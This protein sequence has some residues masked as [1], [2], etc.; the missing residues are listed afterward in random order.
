MLQA[1]AP[2]VHELTLRVTDGWEPLAGATLEGLLRACSGMHALHIH[3][4]GGYAPHRPPREVI[5]A[6]PGHY[7]CTSHLTAQAAHALW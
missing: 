6:S 3:H 4:L 5:F 1:R 2:Y 7:T